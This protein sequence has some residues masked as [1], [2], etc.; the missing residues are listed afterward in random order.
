MPAQDSG[1]LARD[2]DLIRDHLLSAHVIILLYPFSTFDFSFIKIY[3]PALLV[4]PWNVL[5]LMYRSQN[6][7]S[8]E[9]FRLCT[10]KVTLKP[11]PFSKR[12]KVFGS[13]SFLIKHVFT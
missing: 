12:N 9:L 5:H 4:D 11:L 10:Y 8:T 6:S 13:R 2:F 3:E 7:N 1:I